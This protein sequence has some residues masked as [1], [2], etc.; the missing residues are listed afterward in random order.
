MAR[1]ETEP[2]AGDFG[3][4]IGMRLREV[5]LD[6]DLE[7]AEPVADS[8]AVSGA[9][10]R[11]RG[12]VAD[13]FGKSVFRMATTL[14]QDIL[15]VALAARGIV[16]LGLPQ[17]RGPLDMLRALRSLD[18]NDCP[19]DLHVF[20]AELD[21]VMME[22]YDENPEVVHAGTT[23]SAD[24]RDDVGLRQEVLESLA[25][26]AKKVIGG[27]ANAPGSASARP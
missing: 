10:V 16:D 2:A 8:A 18:T 21:A 12:L 15:A 23:T 27:A 1:A 14:P 17:D 5:I 13:V 24:A 4:A 25:D 26:A 3:F 19:V 6:G 11:V 20:R 9:W 22:E 7:D